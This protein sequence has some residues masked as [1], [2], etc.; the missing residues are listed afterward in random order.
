MH[1]SEFAAA[2]P[3]LAR[4]GE[5]RL[6]K[7][8][9]CLVGTIRKDGTPRISPVEPI[10]TGGKLYLGMMWRSTKAL[11][12]LRDPR[13]LVHSIISDKAGTEGEFKLRGRAIDIRDPGEREGYCVALYEKIK[14]RPEGDDWHLFALDIEHAAYQVFEGEQRKTTVWP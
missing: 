8:G 1:W 4:M 2:A 5:E 11:D 12:L 3:D 13:C 10:I 7:W 9:L 14:W 6:E